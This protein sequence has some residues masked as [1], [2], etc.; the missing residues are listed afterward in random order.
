MTSAYVALSFDSIFHGANLLVLQNKFHSQHMPMYV[1]YSA[2][3][4][5][6]LDGV[7][8]LI[9]CLRQ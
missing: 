1:C 3:E 6:G 9:K 5:F 4:G 8:K 7:N 2:D